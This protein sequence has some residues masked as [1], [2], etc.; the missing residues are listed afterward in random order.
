M[1]EGEDEGSQILVKER[2]EGGDFCDDGEERWRRYDRW[3]IILDRG[4]K[5]MGGSHRT[6]S[7]TRGT[8]RAC[9]ESEGLF[10]RMSSRWEAKLVQAGRGAR[11]AESVGLDSADAFSRD[12][13]ANN[14]K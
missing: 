14:K 1:S 12:K 10:G 13:K 7:E 3:G 4:G 2:K 8:R 6:D 11:K 5:P 9:V